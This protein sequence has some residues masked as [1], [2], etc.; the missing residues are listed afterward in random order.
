MQGKCLVS[1]CL[2]HRQIHKLHHHAVVQARSSHVNSS[3]NV[4]TRLVAKAAAV[5][6]PRHADGP[7]LTSCL[8][9]NSQSRNSHPCPCLAPLPPT[10]WPMACWPLEH[11]TPPP[12]RTSLTLPLLWWDIW[13]CLARAS[14]SSINKLQPHWRWCRHTNINECVGERR[15]EITE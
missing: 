11:T 12:R 15:N 7:L 5:F 1:I 8:C 13:I 14:A 6:S 9:V 4:V 3:I 2:H 10:R